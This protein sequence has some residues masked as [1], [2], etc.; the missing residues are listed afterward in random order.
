MTLDLGFVEKCES[1]KLES[2]FFPSKVGGK[3]AWLDLK[4]IPGEKILQC[5][6]CKEPCIFLC[7]IY[8]PYEDSEDAF[9]RTI[10][11]F[12]CRNVECSKLNKNGNLKAFRSQLPRLNEFYPSEPPIEQSDWR[13]DISVNKWVKT[14]YICGILAPSHC[15]KCKTVNYCCRTHQIYDWK[16]GHKEICGSNKKIIRKPEILLTEYE[17]VIEREDKK[18]TD[19]SIK[20]EEEEEE[21]EGEEEEI[22]KYET[23]V[24]K[25]EAGI[26]QNE[27]MPNELL[28]MVNEKEDKLFSTFLSTVDKYPHQILRYDRGGNILY[29][30]EESKINDIPRC[31]ECN[32]ERQFEFQ[33]MPQL[34]NF[35]D[36]GNPLKCIDWGILAVFTCIKSCVPKNGYSKEYIWKQDIIENNSNKK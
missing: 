10:F 24:Q 19:D 2:K 3:P 6:Y 21:E 35:L 33:I 13:T 29:I 25:G 23:M 34:L 31:S 17:I 16:H 9:H 28:N 26:F 7:Q 27:D 11:V 4:N 12:M 15:S 5:E 30:S 8:A 20:E 32:G 22:K 36:L 18:D 14:C 1:W